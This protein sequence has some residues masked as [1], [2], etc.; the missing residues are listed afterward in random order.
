MDNKAWIFSTILYYILTI[1]FYFPPSTT[2]KLQSLNKLLV[3]FFRPPFSLFCNC[4]WF[5]HLLKYK[6][7][8]MS[9]EL[10]EYKISLT[11]KQIRGHFTFRE[12]SFPEEN[13]SFSWLLVGTTAFDRVPTLWSCDKR[14][15][16]SK[17]YEKISSTLQTSIHECP[18]QKK[19][20]SKLVPTKQDQISIVCLLCS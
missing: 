3:L 18:S 15:Q 20:N 11:Q 17:W 1:T 6:R 5:S 8:R 14:K 2:I 16:W 9:M 7:A 10:N 12:Q 19:H 4:V 13:C